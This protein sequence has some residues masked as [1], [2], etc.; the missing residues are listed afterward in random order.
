MGTDVASLILRTFDCG[1]VWRRGKWNAIEHVLFSVKANRLLHSSEKEKEKGKGHVVISQSN[2]FRASTG[3]QAGRIYKPKFPRFLPKN[4]RS[5]LLSPMSILAS[6]I[7]CSLCRSSP[8]ANALP[9]VQRLIN[10]TSTFPFR[11]EDSV[12]TSDLIH[13]SLLRIPLLYLPWT[14]WIGTISIDE[15]K[16]NWK[17]PFLFLLLLLLFFFLS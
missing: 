17:A 1:F 10:A 16:R 12:A 14:Y 9:I 5:W 2:Y 11:F 13:I 4:K 15:I 3:T 6:A 8:H 7:F